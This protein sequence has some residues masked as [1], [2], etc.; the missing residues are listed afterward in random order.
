MVCAGLT[1]LNFLFGL[2]VMPESLSRENRRRIAV[3]QMNPVG[4]LRAVWRY[5]AVAAMLPIF[6]AVQVA[7]Q[8]LQS[9]WVPYTT[10][11]YEWSV[12]QVGASLAVVGLLFA[13]SQGALVRPAVARFGELRTLL[14]SLGVA[15]VGMLLF[16][17]AAEGWMM[18][19][20]TALYCAGLGL[21]NPAIQGLMSRLVAPNEQ[22]L[23]QGAITSVMTGT[24]IVGPILANGLFAVSIDPR[25]PVQVPGAPFFLGS[26]MCLLAL[27]LARRQISRNT[28]EVHELAAH[29]GS[30]AQ[31]AAA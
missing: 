15:V 26:F 7:Q 30:R 18:Y 19:A 12:G 9:V 28:P 20:V 13:F 29:A 16:G 2:L 11:R 31:T 14:I 1:F 4:A 23:L 27:G 21:L 25:L 24:A 17:L 8:G 22:G 5:P 6:L 3:D 10:Y